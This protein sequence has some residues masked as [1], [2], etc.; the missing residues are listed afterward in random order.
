MSQGSSP[1]STCTSFPRG[2]PLSPCQ[3]SLLDISTMS[4]EEI[5]GCLRVVEGRWDDKD[6]APLIGAGGKLLFTREQWQ[7]HFKER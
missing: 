6:E 4:I 2:S 7:T 3:L 1:P 5:F